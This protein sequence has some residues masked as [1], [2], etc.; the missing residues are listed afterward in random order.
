MQDVPNCTY[1]YLFDFCVSRIIRGRKKKILE[2]ESRIVVF[3]CFE[4]E[5]ELVDDDDRSSSKL[6]ANL[7]LTHLNLTHPI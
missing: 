4:L 2:E 5:K 6:T 7:P 1:G 3:D